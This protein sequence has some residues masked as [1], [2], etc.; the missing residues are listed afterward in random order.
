[1]AN[2]D[3]FVDPVLERRRQ[4]ALSLINRQGV[5]PE[6]LGSLAANLGASFLA[7]RN[8][9]RVEREQQEK[10]QRLIEALNN[11]GLFGGQQPPA[12]G[13]P[14]QASAVP[15]GA[16]RQQPGTGVSTPGFNP[17][18]GA[19][20]GVQG[21]QP[22]NTQAISDIAAINPRL[23]LQLGLS[24]RG[25]Q[26]ELAK[27]ERQ[28]ARQVALQDR[29]R[30]QNNSKIVQFTDQ[31]GNPTLLSVDPVS[32]TAKLIATGAQDIAKVREQKQVAFKNTRDAR[33]DL[34][35]DS[36]I[37][38]ESTIAY[39]RFLRSIGGSGPADVAAITAFAKA[40]D[41]GSVVR[42][43]ETGMVLESQALPEQVI[44]QLNK[45]LGQ[46][47]L[48]RRTRND[49]IDVLD[50]V[51]GGVI[52][53]Q[54]QRLNEAAGFATEFGLDPDR[55]TSAVPIVDLSKELADARKRADAT[56]DDKPS[57]FGGLKKAGGQPRRPTAQAVI[58]GP[59][60]TE[61]AASGASD[62]EL[63]SLLGL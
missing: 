8:L 41:P 27:E 16:P 36:K 31:Q 58:T 49:L 13:I 46:G 11:A 61:G 51:Y 54:Q 45:V 32:G 39:K 62:D 56:P 26:A 4:L 63:K 7:K 55:I 24:K 43:S 10:N 2:G 22:I 12:R 21:P 52:E 18:A 6:S 14:D 3:V 50:R 35:K 57:F 15:D 1:M 28:F 5:R 25:Q 20:S 59:Q 44:G 30:Q 9:S 60:V 17:L 23:A 29:K 47:F 37:F 48:T 19:M 40:I 34:K 42:P 33:N 38:I 53:G